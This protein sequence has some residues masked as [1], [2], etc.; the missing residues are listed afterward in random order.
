MIK[1]TIGSFYLQIFELEKN[2]NNKGFFKT[3][4]VKNV[5]R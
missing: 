1:P 4:R 5:G 3:S 2:D